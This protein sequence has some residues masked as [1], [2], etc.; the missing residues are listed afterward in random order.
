MA[1]TRGEPEPRR[2]L[3]VYAVAGATYIGAG[4]AEKAI[5]N[6]VMGPLWLLLVMAAA[7]RLMRS[8][9]TGS[10]GTAEK[11]E[12]EPTV[13]FDAPAD[14]PAEKAGRAP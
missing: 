3:L 13:T 9:D 14:A 6:W 1:N 4:I 7:L 5:L 11:A 10:A 8:R 2:H 12:S